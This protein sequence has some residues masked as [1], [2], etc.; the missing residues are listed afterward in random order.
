MSDELVL[1]EGEEITAT[2]YFEM[3]KSKKEKTSDEILNGTY[4]VCLTLLEKCKRTGQNDA[5]KK[6]FY[7]LDAIELERKAVAAGIDTF[8]YKSDI[9]NTLRRLRIVMFVLSSSVV[10][11]GKFPMTSLRSMRR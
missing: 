1:G 5:A 10:M 9:V 2:Q 11:R 4:Q 3:L 8:I 7:H 6:I